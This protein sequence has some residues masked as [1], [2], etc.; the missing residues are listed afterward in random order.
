MK[1]FIIFTLISLFS[2]PITPCSVSSDFVF[3]TIEESAQLSGAVIV[4]TVENEKDPRAF[5][6]EDIFLTNAEYYKGCGPEK[7][8]ISGYSMSSMCGFDTP[9]PGSKVIVFVCK[10]EQGWKLNRFAAYAGQFEFNPDNMQKLTSALGGSMTCE[11]GAF[12]YKDCQPRAPQKPS[13]P[14]LAPVAVKID[15]N[16]P[17][18]PEILPE[19]L[20]E[21]VPEKPIIAPQ[22]PT[23][24]RPNQTMMNQISPQTYPST[25]SNSNNNSQVIPILDMP[26]HHPDNNNPRTFEIPPPPVPQVQP[27]N[28]GTVSSRPNL[29][30]PSKIGNGFRYQ[31]ALM[32][33]SNSGN[34]NSGN[35]GSM[36]YNPSNPFISE[37]TSQIPQGFTSFFSRIGQQ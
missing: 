37:G 32:R 30:Q 29:I 27:R 24:T 8:R 25:P 26:I 22:T 14:R 21:P 1:T 6:D 9:K 4:G 19:L 2:L 35:S 34:S 36:V 16:A 28:P 11:N 23:F 12:A 10:D 3:A 17:L 33:N 20:P 18:Q 13:P 31:P 7:V 5:I 15:P